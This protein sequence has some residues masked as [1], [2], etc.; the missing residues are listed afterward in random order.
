MALKQKAAPS[1]QMKKQTLVLYLCACLAT[2][3]FHFGPHP[4]SPGLHVK[5]SISLPRVSEVPHLAGVS[6]FHV[7]RPLVS[8]DCFEKNLTAILHY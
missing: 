8:S 7:N 3:R 6:C 1:E 2:T 4:A 5:I